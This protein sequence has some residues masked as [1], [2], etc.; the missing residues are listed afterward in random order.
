MLTIAL[1]VALGVLVV[2]VAVEVTVLVVDITVL[3]VELCVTAG[4][5]VELLLASAAKGIFS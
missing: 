2:D 4:G 1:L 5:P 3:E